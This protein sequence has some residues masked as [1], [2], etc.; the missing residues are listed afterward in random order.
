MN[1]REAR[2]MTERYRRLRTGSL[3]I[4]STYQRPLNAKRATQ[5]AAAWDDNLAGTIIVNERDTGGLWVVDGQH[6]LAAARLAGIEWLDAEVHSGRTPAE[7]AELWWRH[8]HFRASPKVINIFNA[9]L[10]AGDEEAESIV[11]AVK[12]A[13][14]EINL[15]NPSTKAPNQTI[16]VG[17]LQ[18]IH[19][20]L[21]PLG[22]TR[23]LRVLRTAWP[24]TREA[25]NAVPLSGVGGFLYVYQS[26]PRFDY[27]RLAPKLGERPCSTF[28]RRAAELTAGGVVIGGL[29]GPRLGFNKPG[30]RAA[31]LEAYNRNLRGR[32]LPAAAQ[33]DMKRLSLGQDPWLDE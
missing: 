20:E 14:V 18:S 11:A 1:N 7:E 33:S 17:M 26:H 32:A 9:R 28:I 3:R 25:L 23:V 15:S 13:G 30:P 19:G 22:L 2:E 24:E 27:D 10:A 12:A 31:V 21:G 6:R 16:A 8:N 29:G 4:D 5:M